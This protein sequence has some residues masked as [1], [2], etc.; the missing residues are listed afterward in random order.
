M[1]AG[2]G[3]VTSQT[4]S[5]PRAREREG[6]PAS[7]W[8]I[9]PPDQ[10]RRLVSLA[11]RPSLTRRRVEPGG[12]PWCPLISR[13]VRDAFAVVEPHVPRPVGCEDL[14]GLGDELW[15]RREHGDERSP[16][17][18]LLEVLLAHQSFVGQS[19]AD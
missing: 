12:H 10:N 2:P 16:R 9:M 3:R 5:G 14:P 11:V 18:S 6:R 17:F 19:A 15:L 1:C 4:K 7:Q 13:E 8:C